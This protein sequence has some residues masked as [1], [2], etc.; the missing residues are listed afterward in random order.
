MTGDEAMAAYACGDTEA[1]RAV[2]DA[3]SPRL[4]A[5]VR[6]KVREDAMAAEI[7]QQTFLNMHLAR[8]SF[9][10]GAKVLPWA[11]QIATHLIIDA[12]RKGWR[13]IASDLAGDGDGA[14]EQLA[15]TDGT[16]EELAVARETAGR[17]QAAYIRLGEP[18]RQA[19]EM[20]G[21]GLPYAQAASRLNT[22]VMGV[23]LRV[24]RA[25]LALRSAIEDPEDRP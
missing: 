4:E 15:S 1:F 24:R 22:S 23:K 25:L 8:G 16:G 6:K 18:Q 12:R 10:P 13:E 14:A 19:L 3:V 21:S 5:H 9:I 20:R 11:L 17:L 7:I 2:Y